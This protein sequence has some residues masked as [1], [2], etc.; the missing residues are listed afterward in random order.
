[1]SFL[2]KLRD[3]VRYTT[4]EALKIQIAKDVDNAREYFQTRQ[5]Y[6]PAPQQHSGQ[7]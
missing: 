4:L 6:A 7:T 5:G 3:E 2:H 1:V